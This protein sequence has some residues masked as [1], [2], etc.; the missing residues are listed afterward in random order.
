MNLNA[1]TLGAETATKAH[2]DAGARRERRRLVALAGRGRSGRGPLR[3]QM[4]RDAEG[5]LTATEHV[6]RIPS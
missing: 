5:H 1:V 2:T 3:R 4:R 6:A